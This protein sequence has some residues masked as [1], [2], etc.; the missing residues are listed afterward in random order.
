MTVFRVTETMLGLQQR[1]ERDLEGDTKPSSH[2]DGD[3]GGMCAQHSAATL[4][5]TCA[6]CLTRIVR[7]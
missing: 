7:G 4:Q 6:S 5:R 1:R 2:R 3:D